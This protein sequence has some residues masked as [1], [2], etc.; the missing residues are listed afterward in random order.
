MLDEL[1]T[2]FKSGNLDLLLVILI[3]PLGV[4]S[5]TF[6]GTLLDGLNGLIV[7]LIGLSKSSFSTGK[8]FSVVGNGL[9]EGGDGFDLL[10][11][12]FIESTDVLI[13]SGLVSLVIG[14][15][16]SL[17]LLEGSGDLVKE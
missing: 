1:D 12:L 6:S 7:V 11:D 16:F 14:I 17:I 15:S 8:D 9:F 3:S 4:L 2:L 10:S 13:T 5:F